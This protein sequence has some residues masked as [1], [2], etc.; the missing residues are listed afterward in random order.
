MGRTTAFLIRWSALTAAAPAERIID[1]LT[2]GDFNGGININSGSLAETETGL[3]TAHVIGGKRVTKLTITASAPPRKAEV[4]IVDAFDEHQCSNDERVSSEL[5]FTYGASTPLNVDLSGDTSFDFEVHH[6]DLPS[7]DITLTVTDGDSSDTVTLTTTGLGILACPFSNFTGIDFSNV[8]KLEVT[9]VGPAAVDLHI[10]RIGTS[11][12][13]TAVV[14]DFLWEDSDGDGIQ[15]PDEGAV[16]GVTVRLYDCGPDGIVGTGDDVLVD[17][18]S[19]VGGLYL[20]DEVEAGSYYVE[21]DLPAGFTFT[22]QDQGGDDEKDSDVDP[23]TGRTTCFRVRP[24]DVQLQWD[25]GLVREQQEELA[26]IGDLVWHDLDGDGVQDAGEPGVDGVTVN[27][28]LCG[29]DGVAGTGDD[30]F[31]STTVTA[32]GGL[33][34]FSNLPPGD[35]YVE[36]V[37][38]AGWVFTTQD[39]GGD[40]TVDSDA[41]PADGRAICTTLSPGETDL[42]W[43]AGLVREP[44]NGG[45]SFTIGFWKTHPDAWPVDTLTLGGVVYTKEQALALLNTP[46]RGDATIILAHQLIG[47]KLNVANGA[48]PTDVAQAIADADDWLIAHPVGTKPKGPSRE[49]GILLSETLDAYN[50]GDIGPGHCDDQGSF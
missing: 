15:D 1:D 48:D 14:G 34:L 7:L 37:L 20:F 19:T 31:V 45:C 38:P 22:L 10:L 29:P 44:N 40:D 8:K 18:T 41:N 3:D 27:L 23:T 5:Q 35:Y 2:E 32:G 9:F 21:F 17:T 36:F 11:L 47:A 39:A 25:A 13:P 24:N 33:Y 43:D 49:P 30:V 6:L 50:N 28:Y 12:R 16:G 4:I 46:P 42:T 26:A